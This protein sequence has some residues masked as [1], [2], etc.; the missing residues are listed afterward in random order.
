MPASTPGSAR[1]PLVAQA[2]KPS[3]SKGVT[4]APT[5]RMG[6]DVRAAGDPAASSFN[7]A[8]GIGRSGEG[9]SQRQLRVGFRLRPRVR[10]VAVLLQRAGLRSARRTGG[11]EAG[12]R[13]S[14][15]VIRKA[16]G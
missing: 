1:A 13:R 12:L 8:G 11:G 4:L 2:C 7:R 15:P 10:R 3:F 14:R 9:N 5:P 16:L 6:K